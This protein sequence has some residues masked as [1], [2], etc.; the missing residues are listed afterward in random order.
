[1]ACVGVSELGQEGEEEQDHLGIQDIRQ[2][3]LPENGGIGVADWG[4]AGYGE[5][6]L[7][8]DQGSDA[9]IDEVGGT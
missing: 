8:G 4:A 2:E 5:C 9:E 6:A 1:M 3:G 7:P